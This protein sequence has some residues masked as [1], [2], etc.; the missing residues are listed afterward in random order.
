MLSLPDV[1]PFDTIRR[2][3]PGG[4]EFWSARDLQPLLGYAKWE[5]F[6]EAIDRAMESNE[7]A[8]PGTAHDHFPAAGKMVEVGSGAERTVLDYH[9]SRH[10][11]YL[12]AMNGD[13]RKPEIAAAQM[14]FAVQTHRAELAQAAALAM[15]AD[16][17]LAQLEMLKAV[18]VEQLAL[19]QRTHALEVAATNAPIRA[20][21]AARA[22]IHAACQ[23]FGKVHPKS[24]P[25]A[26]RAFKEAF[27]FQG[28][29]LAAYDDLPQSRLQEALNWLQVQ[30]MTFSAQRPLL[31]GE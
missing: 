18:R 15:P 9:L 16:P 31:D 4:G 13:S 10:A 3:R 23:Q 19:E 17:V 29:P 21:S 20:N 1:S 2:V 5:R 8:A 26:Y 14:Y 22:S 24:F 6:R 30:I 12:I 27:G 25:G 28:A 7:N 11:C